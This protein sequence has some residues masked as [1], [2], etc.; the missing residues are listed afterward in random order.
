VPSSLTPEE[1][2]ANA[3]GNIKAEYLTRDVYTKR[4]FIEHLQDG[5]QPHYLFSNP[6][7]GLRFEHPDWNAKEAPYNVGFLHPG[8]R[9]LLI[10]DRRVL[11]VGGD[12]E[13]DDLTEEFAYT[14]LINSYTLTKWG[15]D[16]I[17]FTHQDG[18]EITFFVVGPTGD[19]LANDDLVDEASAYVGKRIEEASAGE[20]PMLR[21]SG[22]K[23]GPTETRV[24]DPDADDIESTSTRI[25]DPDAT[26]V[27]PDL[28]ERAVADENSTLDE[29]DEPEEKSFREQ[30]EEI[31]EQRAQKE[32]GEKSFRERV[33][34]I[35][36]QN[37]RIEE[38]TKQEGSREKSFRERVEEIRQQR[39]Q[40]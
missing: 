25:Y 16:P 13:G 27:K 33:E 21:S 40:K 3:L 28:D 19:T 39:R 9:Y 18:R 8:Q 14:D 29:S 22:S 36:E 31:R 26:V 1:L 38:Q 10:T 35:R 34:E 2:A 32:S 24:F 5:E 20:E 15:S 30:V 4:P 7:K 37:A 17:V 23:S 11:F 6:D 12:P